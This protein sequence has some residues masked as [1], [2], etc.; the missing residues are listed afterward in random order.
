[1]TCRDFTAGDPGI[2]S[3]PTLLRVEVVP[4]I[5]PDAPISADATVISPDHEGALKE[6]N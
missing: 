2:I 5:A 4:L 3:S 1:M 6:E